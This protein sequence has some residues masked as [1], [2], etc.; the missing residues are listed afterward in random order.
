MPGSFAHVKAGTVAV[1]GVAWAQHRGI[2]EVEVR[3]DDGPWQTARLAESLSKDTWRQWVWE[4]PATKGTHTI[5]CRAIDGTGAA[6]SATS[7]GIRPDGSTGLDS[8]V[9]MVA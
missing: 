8:V 9:V 7:R 6:Q 4:W 1:A 2:S 5:E 3:V